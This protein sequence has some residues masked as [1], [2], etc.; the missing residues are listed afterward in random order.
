ML[1][2]SIETAQQSGLFDEIM[3]STDSDEIKEIALKYGAK[4]PFMRSEQTSNDYALHQRP[5]K[6]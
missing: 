1:A 3:V 6:Q 5:T 4:V 2:Y